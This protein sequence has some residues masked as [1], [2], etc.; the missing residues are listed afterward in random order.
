M[1]KI[2]ARAAG[3]AAAALTI[4][5]LSAGVASASTPQLKNVGGRTPFTT[6]TTIGPQ[7]VAG[8]K[9]TWANTVTF[10]RKTRFTGGADVTDALCGPQADDCYIIQVKITD[11]G[12]VRTVK[13]AF[14]PNQLVA[15]GKRITGAAQSGTFKGTGTVIF[16]ASGYPY[17]SMVAP[18]VNG[19]I[20]TPDWYKQFFGAGTRF[21]VGD[22]LVETV[23]YKV[24]AQSWVTGAD[25]GQGKRDGNITR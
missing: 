6:T 11:T 18:N 9:G 16:Y 10:T 20:D 4:V 19:P 17:A 14:Q 13:H 5:T 22:P 3:I 12:T 25:L 2:F 8:G 1:N 15:A 23:T 21:G 7:A 24:G